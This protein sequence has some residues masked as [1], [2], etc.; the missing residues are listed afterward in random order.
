MFIKILLNKDI[1]TTVYLY[2][3]FSVKFDTSSLEV[4]FDKVFLSL[5]VSP[6]ILVTKKMYFTNHI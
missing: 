4:E 6:G 5:S 3:A 2:E 1:T